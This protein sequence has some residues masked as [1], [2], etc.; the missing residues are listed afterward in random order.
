[1]N[2]SLHEFFQEIFESIVSEAQNITFTTF[3]EPFNVD[4]SPFK[5]ID[6]E[7][8]MGIYVHI[9]YEYF[10]DDTYYFYIYN[11]KGDN[12]K[13]EFLEHFSETI[14]HHSFSYM[15]Q[16]IDALIYEKYGFSEENMLFKYNFQKTQM[17]PEM[18][19]AEN[20]EL[21]KSLYKR[22]IDRSIRKILVEYRSHIS[23]EASYY[24]KGAAKYAYTILDFEEI[25]QRVNDDDFSYQI[26]EAIAAYDNS[27]FLACASTLGVAVETLCLALLDKHGIEYESEDPTMIGRLT[28][29]LKTNNIIDRRMKN[30][31]MQAYSTRNMVSHSNKGY[32]VSNDCHSLFATIHSLASEKF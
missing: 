31:L 19:A 29:I 14:K 20:F 13:V 23:K 7:N 18:S 28:N 22:E 2:N 12:G 9:P 6:R 32:V 1:M 10:N 8:L 3:K 21:F 11:S 25:I 16:Y 5:L 30:R 4:P 26:N 15:H 17:F 24:S 27:L